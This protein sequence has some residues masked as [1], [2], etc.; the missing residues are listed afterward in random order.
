MVNNIDGLRPSPKCTNTYVTDMAMEKKIKVNNVRDYNIF[1]HSHVIK[2][3][4]KEAIAHQKVLPLFH[5]VKAVAK[6]FHRSVIQCTML[7]KKCTE[8]DIEYVRILKPC[9]TRW[10][11]ICHTV[12]SLCQMSPA[13][14]KYLEEG[15]FDGEFADK[16]P[17]PTMSKSMGQMLNSPL[18]IKKAAVRLQA[19]D[20]RTIQHVIPTFILL[21][22]HSKTDTYMFSSQTRRAFVELFEIKLKH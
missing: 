15:A 8:L 22:N 2:R 18:V 14:T 6:S 3:A 16:I 13:F 1:C 17:K 19:D 11:S 12:D 4:L 21:C 7:C 5:R 9:D 10:N 20:S